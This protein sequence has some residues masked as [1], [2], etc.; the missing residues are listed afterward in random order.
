[1]NIIRNLIFASQTEVFNPSTYQLL[2]NDVYVQYY[3][4][5][6]CKTPNLFYQLCDI[7]FQRGV[8]SGWHQWSVWLFV[9]PLRQRESIHL[10]APPVTGRI[11]HI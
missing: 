10:Q 2:I 8:D 1:M 11:G 5:P 7:L 6:C 9:S 4:G 3:Q